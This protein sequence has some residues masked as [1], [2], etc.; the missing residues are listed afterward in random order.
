MV[1]IRMVLEQLLDRGRIF[2]SEADFQFAFAWQ[3]KETYGQQIEVRLEYTPW[4]YSDKMHIDIVAMT[5]SGLIPIELKYRKA[6]LD[7]HLDNGDHIKLKPHTAHDTGAYE[8]LSDIQRLE[9][10]VR[11]KQYSI[12]EAYAI[13][14]TNDSAYWR[15]TRRGKQDKQPNDIAFRIFD[16]AELS[17][18]RKWDDAAGKGTIKGHEDPIV[19]SGKY[20]MV[21]H[22]C[23]PC[24]IA[25][26]S[27][28]LSKKAVPNMEFKYN[29]V[30][31][32]GDMV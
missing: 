27:D 11:S 9:E 15:D 4:K 31:I 6:K 2:C 5:E 19:L 16:G 3:L 30:K 1:E 23:K 21:W 25:N 12:H 22:A 20:K 17:G 18:E 7:I 26:V 32:M 28:G 13:M 14:L 29:I 8:F 24:G 10:L